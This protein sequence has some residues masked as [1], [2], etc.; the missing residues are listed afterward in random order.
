MCDE[1][2]LAIS[3]SKYQEIGCGSS[4]N[5]LAKSAMGLR[6]KGSSG[7]VLRFKIANR[8]SNGKPVFRR[9]SNHLAYVAPLKSM[10]AELQQANALRRYGN[11]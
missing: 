4:Y 10:D 5:S 2:C 11:V 6:T 7:N 9:P 3:P 1:Y 8:Q